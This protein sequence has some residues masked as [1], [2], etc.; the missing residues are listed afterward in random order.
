M[1][2]PLQ[3]LIIATAF[4]LIWAIW[5]H[6]RDKSLTWSISIEYLLIAALGLILLLGVLNI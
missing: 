1:M 5:H 2:T 6:R 3:I 4:Y